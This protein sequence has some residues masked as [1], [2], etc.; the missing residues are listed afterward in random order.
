MQQVRTVLDT[1]DIAA[2]AEFRR[3]F[4]AEED[5]IASA[6]A[7]A[8]TMLGIF[9]F[10]LPEADIDRIRV[11]GIMNTALN[12]QLSSFKLWMSGHTV[13]SGSLFRQVIEGISLA[14]LF[15][16]RELPFL[17]RYEDDE[18]SGRHAVRDL[19]RHTKDARVQ[20]H[21]MNA[22]ESA[23]HFHH[24]FAHLSKLTIAASASFSKGGIPQ[25]GG[26]FDAE[27]LPQYVKEARNRARFARVLPN[28]VLGVCS[29]LARW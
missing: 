8:L 21:A 12:L 10:R 15:S 9:T 17:Q 2:R 4:R 5:F 29:N 13:A 23:Y 18:Y 27:K 14:F 25:L 3:H 6:T 7:T 24:R 1:T 26:H 11:V 20:P 19:K 28:A 22:I 16:A